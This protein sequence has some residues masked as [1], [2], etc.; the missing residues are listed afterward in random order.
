MAARAGLSAGAADQASRRRLRPSA[1]AGELHA[2]LL[3]HNA[4]G[5]TC[6]VPIEQVSRIERVRA[7]QIQYLGGRRTMQYRGASL[8]LVSLH[9]AATRGQNWTRRSMAW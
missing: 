1:A 5:E 3:F 8:P 6:A 9:D 2:L 4:P 7:E